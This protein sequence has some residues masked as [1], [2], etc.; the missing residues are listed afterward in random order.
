VRGVSR[1]P[2]GR[3][4]GMTAATLHV[5][6][7][8]PADAYALWLWANDDASRV[9]SFDRPLISWDSHVTWLREQLA[10]STSMVLIADGP[11]AQPVGSVRY[12]TE[13]GWRTARLSYV[14]APESRG[15]G[16]SVGLV[17]EGTRFLLGIHR[18]TAIIAT[19]RTSNEASMRLFQKLGWE[20]V[21]GDQG[22]SIHFRLPAP[23]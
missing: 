20:E 21:S 15:Q 16:L 18:R 23:T 13:D 8:Q 5:R 1:S 7:A 2:L 11:N 3:Y 19:V 6:P 12:D 22:T 14:V 9:A 17:Q 10:S 4:S